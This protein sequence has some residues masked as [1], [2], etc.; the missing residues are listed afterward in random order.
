[1]SRGYNFGPNNPQWNY[2][3]ALWLPPNT[4]GVWVGNSTFDDFGLVQVGGQENR[5]Y[6]G[7]GLGTCGPSGTGNAFRPLPFTP[8]SYL[9]VNLVAID[10]CG[11]FQLATVHFYITLAPPPSV[12]LTANGV[13]SSTTI[14]YNQSV[15]LSWQA[16][17]T[18]ISSCSASWSGNVGTSGTETYGPLTAAR[19]FTV[20]CTNAAGAGA[21]AVTVNVS[22]PPPLPTV[23]LKVQGPTGGPT[24]GPLTVPYLSQITLSWTSTNSLGCIAGGGTPTVP[25]GGAKTTAGSELIGPLPTGQYFFNLSCRNVTGSSMDLVPVTVQVP[26]VPSVDIKAR[27]ATG[28]TSDGPL[29]VEYNNPAFIL[30]TTGNATSC[31]GSDGTAAWRMS[32]KS[33]QNPTGE[34]TG[35]LTATTTF[36]LTC[37]GLG[38]STAD[39]VTVQIAPPPA[40]FPRGLFEGSF[41]AP[42][43]EL[44][45]QGELKI[46]FDARIQDN[47]P[48]GFTDLI[49]PKHEE[50]T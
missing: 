16:S 37:A 43:I 50:G 44:N 36:I 21:A 11:S 22:P 12:T 42:R 2:T 33:L 46:H 26:P 7:Q 32:P 8:G 18:N 30:W 31:V 25:W 17:G 24:N 45:R 29:T 9:G 6:F 20:T 14:G 41:V 40:D 10:T 28:T 34:S 4:T 1:M 15:S 19:T 27:T 39:S 23:D 3:E 48:P 5:T 38:G 47:P 13:S 49:P 35:N